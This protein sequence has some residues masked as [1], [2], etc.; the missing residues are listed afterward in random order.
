MR[1]P[2]PALRFPLPTLLA[3]AA[4][5]LGL[6]ASQAEN[7]PV[8]MGISQQ[9]QHDSNLLRRDDN[10]EADTISSTGLQIGLDKSYGRQRYTLDLVGRTNRY[11][12]F[13]TYNNNSY[14]F[15]AGFRTEIGRDIALGLNGN[16][17]QELARF[18]DAGRAGVRVK[19]PRN[20]RQLNARL[21]Y[22]L[23][24]P[25]SFNANVSRF[26]Q[27]Y[28]ISTSYFEDIKTTTTSAGIT[29]SPR[30]LVSFGLGISQARSDVQTGSLS[31]DRTRRSIDLTARWEVTGV[32]SLA[33]QLSF[34]KEE[35]E[36][37]G[38]TDWSDDNWSALATWNYRP[39]GRLVFDTTLS[40]F[41]G[42]NGQ[43]TES[44]FYTFSQDESTTST[45][46]RLQVG[47]EAT[48]KIRLNA[49]A[50]YTLYDRSRRTA[51][52]IGTL[53]F[54]TS[55]SKSSHYTVLGLSASW[56]PYRWLQLNCGAQRLQRTA[57]VA[58]GY[59]A[60]DA[61]VAYCSGVFYINGMY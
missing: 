34:G 17:S 21:T 6:P 49:T 47:W 14:D 12:K 37:P 38:V 55:S 10:A 58:F 33:G 56:T 29:W 39:R 54:P 32:S 61:N 20:V 24:G 31:Y 57:D 60:F 9:V 1:P 48:A 22:G 5:A 15:D 2:R 30:Q 25:L 45:T 23:Y 16:A 11:S 27:D 36:I 41:T 28:D 52:A 3:C 7:L 4:G 50:D 42:S 44:G 18:E 59:N 46:L 13:D 40:R 35:R 53:V 43:Y 8:S 26:D 51:S 19:N